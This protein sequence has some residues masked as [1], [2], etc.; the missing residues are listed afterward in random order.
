MVWRRATRWRK[1]WAAIALAGLP[2]CAQLKPNLFGGP[3]T[4][5]N[6]STAWRPADKWKQLPREEQ[7]E[8][9]PKL[10]QGMS[11]EALKQGEMLALADVVLVAL[12]NNLLVRDAWLQA[13]AAAKNIGLA[14]S[15]YLPN[16]SA[17]VQMTY[18]N[19]LLAASRGNN[20]P[21]APPRQSAPITIEQTTVGPS[22]DLN[23]TL[24]DLG[25]R[26][27]RVEQA[28]YSLA[29]ANLTHNATIQ[30]VV[31]QVEQAYVQYV[32]AKALLD[33]QRA[34]V[35]TA[36]V[37][38][39]AAQ[40][41]ERAGL[42][43]VAD[44]L[45]AKTSLSQAEYNYVSIEGQIASL[46]GSLATAMGLP[47][48]VNVNVGLLP[49]DLPL[50]QVAATADSYIAQAIEARPDLSA[51]RARA[52]ATRNRIT[53]ARSGLFP[54]LGFSA[55]FGKLYFINPESIPGNNISA[56]LTLN[57]PIFTGLSTYYSIQQAEI[58]AHDARVQVANLEQQIILQVWS[59]YYALKT[60]T[61]QL[62]AAR[63][64][65][66]SAKQSEDVALGRYKAG[67][68]NILDLLSAQNALANARAQEVQARSAWFLAL[69]ELAHA[70]GVLRLPEK[71]NPVP[72]L[73]ENK[74]P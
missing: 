47:A 71:G 70:T 52:E 49:E 12:E 46:I 20:A 8:L 61:K 13:Q 18:S 3:G 41:R 2:G 44:V 26:S 19:R 9:V 55:S 4:S 16:L 48:T 53:E 45:L 43:T 68:G 64:L 72:G 15:Q 50:N 58:Q 67:V 1:T 28:M 22:I 5:P 6:P 36:K 14:R 29:A 24:L 35:E 10:P 39:D 33:V 42:A 31:L 7:A 57:I 74:S 51:A 11:V 27:S 30:N 65:L 25:G 32:N 40:V 17:T 37:S 59:S 34:T 62:T 54:T 60:A 63:D 21:G 23:W 73:L 56:G 69:A 66:V 38:L